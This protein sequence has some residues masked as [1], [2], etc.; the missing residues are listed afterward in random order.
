MT[1]KLSAL[2]AGHPLPQVSFLRFLVLI[3]VRGRVDPRAIVPPEGL[4]K[5]EKIDLIGTRSLDLPVCSLV[6]QLITEKTC[7][8]MYICVMQTNVNI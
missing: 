4:G 6:L 8:N 5:L 1:A 2:C 3:S 7:I